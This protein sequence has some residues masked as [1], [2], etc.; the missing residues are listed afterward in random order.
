MYFD[1][2]ETIRWAHSVRQIALRNEAIQQ[3]MVELVVLPSFPSLSTVVEIFQ[4]VPV[5]VGAQNM[6]P[7]DRGPYTGEVNVGTLKQVGCT[8][9][10]IGH[11][12]RRKLFGETIS[13]IQHKV[14]LAIENELTPLIC[15]GETHET[16]PTKAAS[17]CIAFIKDAVARVAP[18]NTDPLLFAYEPEWA[19]G[20][21]TPASP[22]YVR[23]VS[24]QIREW[25]KT[26]PELENSRLIYG[27]SAGPGS[28]SSLS[29]AVDGLFLGRFAHEPSALENILNEISPDTRLKITDQTN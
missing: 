26:R 18:S 21:D 12:E 9:I 13:N 6:A 24:K 25:L 11:A 5:F 7:V 27:G 4:D 1:H 17:T 23:S 2:E 22:E 10:E 3:G 16:F 28:L 20:A 15:V 29:G 8:H 14:S 19:I